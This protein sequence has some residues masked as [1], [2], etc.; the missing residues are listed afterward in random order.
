[1]NM[2]L[3]KRNVLM[4][5][6][7]VTAL[8]IKSWFQDFPCSLA[9]DYLGNVAA[10]F[11]IFFLIAIAAAPKLHRIWVAVIA[12]TIVEAIELTD[13]YGVM[14]KYLRSIR[15]PG[16]CSRCCPCIFC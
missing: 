13:G 9:R 16:Q 1:M 14:T 15:L 8:L 12:L 5:L 6:V 3:R 10:S 4:V 11:A 7:G 2:N